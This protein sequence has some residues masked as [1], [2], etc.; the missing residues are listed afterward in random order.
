MHRKEYQVVPAEDMEQPLPF[1]RAIEAIENCGVQVRQK[2]NGIKTWSG[3]G[4]Q[5]GLTLML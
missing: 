1:S 5:R 3:G 4:G 2:K